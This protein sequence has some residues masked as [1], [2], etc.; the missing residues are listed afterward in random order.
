MTRRASR[1]STFSVCWHQRMEGSLEMWVM[2]GDEDE[3]TCENGSR[4]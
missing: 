2:L 4:S 1:R 3:G